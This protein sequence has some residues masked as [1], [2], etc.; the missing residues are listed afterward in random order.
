VKEKKR[1]G[2]PLFLNRSKRKDYVSILH[3]RKGS[4]RKGHDIHLLGN[5]KRKE[6]IKKT[7][8]RNI[9]GRTELKG[10]RLDKGRSAEQ[11]PKGGK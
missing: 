2:Y 4:A 8:K 11:Y 10:I 1:E 5:T 3:I 9:K 6:K 7:G